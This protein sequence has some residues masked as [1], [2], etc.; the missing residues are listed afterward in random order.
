[1]KK[2]SFQNDVLP[3]KNR[4]YRLALRITMS[5]EDAED[6]VQDTLIR[7]WNRRQEWDIIDSLQAYALTVCR[8]LALDCI[9]KHGRDHLSLDEAESKTIHES[10]YESIVKQD[11]INIVKRIVYSLPEKQR[12]MM[13][14]RDFEGMSYK[15]I[16]KIMNV[17]Q[18]QVKVNIYRARQSVKN[19]YDKIENNEL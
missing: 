9:K 13:Q 11:K 3:L 5:R 17:S 2:I 12:T 15:D 7:V 6:I 8:N 18:E 4:L 14:L 1:M 19:K 10:P 16:A